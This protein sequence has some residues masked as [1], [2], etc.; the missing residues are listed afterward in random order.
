M[1]GT[2]TKG[3]LISKSLLFPIIKTDTSVQSVTQNG[4]SIK[5]MIWIQPSEDQ[6]H[7]WFVVSHLRA[8]AHERWIERSASPCSRLLT[9]RGDLMRKQNQGC[10][11]W[12]WVLLQQHYNSTISPCPQW[13]TKFALPRKPRPNCRQ[14]LSK[15]SHFVSLTALP[16]GIWEIH[17]YESFVAITTLTPVFIWPTGK[18]RIHQ[19]VCTLRSYFM[20]IFRLLFSI[21]GH[22]P[23]MFTCSKTHYF[24][25]T[26]HY[27]STSVHLLYEGSV[28]VPVSLRPPRDWTPPSSSDWSALTVLNKHH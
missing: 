9:L 8:N 4:P 26:I 25:H 24:S 12:M 7:F 10:C 11:C 17:T 18:V 15:G 28:W 5:H 27:C 21:I 23:E 14:W 1:P 20:L 6:N 13:E 19:G 22:L 2:R 16:L 3:F